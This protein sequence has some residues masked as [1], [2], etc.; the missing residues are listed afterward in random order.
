VRR[1]VLGITRALFGRYTPYL[2][3]AIFWTFAELF[4]PKQLSVLLGVLSIR[5]YWFWWVAPLV[6]A[7]VLSDPVVRRKAVYLQAIVAI[8]VSLFAILQFGAPAEDTVNTYAIVDGVEVRPAEVVTTGRVRVAATFSFIT[9]FTDFSVLVPVLLLSIGLGEKDPKARMAA[10]VATLVSAAALPMSGSRAPFVLSMAL[11][12]LVAWRAGLIF[13]PAGRRVILLGVAAGFTMVFAFPDALQ[14]VFDRFGGDDTQ[15]RFEQWSSVF[16]PIAL[17]TEDYPLMGLGTGMMQSFRTQLGVPVGEY[18]LETE[19]V[20]VLVELGAL[21]YV[22]V[23]VT[24]FGLIVTLW[25]SSKILAKAGRSAAAGAAV[26]Y[27]LLTFYGA[28]TFDHT[29]AA[30]YFFGFGIILREVIQAWPIVYGHTILEKVQRV[31]SDN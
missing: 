9:G 18:A 31:Q 15:G 20:R 2:K 7:S 19:L 11:C 5:A 28:M 1:D 10:L 8:V 30:L 4:N 14:G 6:V 27:M 21:G 26:S 22:L 23:W 17:T 3:L 29:F 16:P 13:T 24:R 25:R 12:A